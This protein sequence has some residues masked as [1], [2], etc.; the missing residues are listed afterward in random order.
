[1]RDRIGLMHDRIELTY[2]SIRSI[3]GR[4]RFVNNKCCRSLYIFDV[5][6]L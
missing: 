3:N 5:E 2:G 1:M 6:I 4:K